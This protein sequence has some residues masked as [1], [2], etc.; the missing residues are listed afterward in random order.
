MSS[1]VYFG[2]N[3]GPGGRISEE[4]RSR[5][6]NF[7]RAVPSAINI[8]GTRTYTHPSYELFL[9]YFPL[10]VRAARL[11]EQVPFGTKKPFYNFNGK[12]VAPFCQIPKIVWS[13]GERKPQEFLDQQKAR[14][15][16]IETTASGKPALT[17]RLS[18]VQV[19][20]LIKDTNPLETTD[21]SV[22]TM[23]IF[24]YKTYRRLH[25]LAHTIIR[26]FQY[27]LTDESTMLTNT[28]ASSMVA[29]PT[30]DAS[31]ETPSGWSKLRNSKRPILRV[32][33]IHLVETHQAFKKNPG[34]T[35][36]FMNLPRAYSSYD[37]CCHTAGDIPSSPG[38]IFPYVHTLARNDPA[39]I[40]A[41]LNNV[42]NGLHGD[43]EKANADMLAT[44][45]KGWSGIHITPWGDELTHIYVGINL[46]M[47]TGAQLRTFTT[48][49]NAYAGFILLGAHFTVYVD[50][51]TYVPQTHVQLQSDFQK[52]SPHS[53]S[54]ER[55][56]EMITYDDDLT[57]VGARTRC[58]SLYDVS[59]AL[60]SN[61]YNSNNRESIAKEARNLC[62][63]KDVYLPLNP[64]TISRVLV[65]MATGIGESEIPLH[66][67]AIFDNDKNHRLLSAFGASCPSFLIDGGRSIPLS[68]NFGY[69]KKIK[70]S[71]KQVEVDVHTM[72][73]A[74]KPFDQAVKD[75]DAV[76]SEKLVKTPAG[77]A[78][79]S[80]VSARAMIREYDGQGG[81]EILAALR[82]AAKVVV[83]DNPSAANMKK[84]RA[85]EESE[86]G[87]SKK[88]KETFDDF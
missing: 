6:V 35:K 7:C 74:V 22:S 64:G 55:L 61:G 29:I 20:D 62:F 49:Q 30:G 68:G 5:G 28:R 27:S 11:S 60:R 17:A 43:D 82:A 75:L 76:L 87:S 40:P 41:I 59:L 66:H 57:R 16:A 71:G 25:A 26:I 2:T 42:L 77:T 54:L 19:R 9:D 13:Y 32:N 10:A 85:E 23:N 21:I 44:L 14:F 80:R 18:V 46:A 48:S 79:A 15:N 12:N 31:F 78:M 36:F 58:R 53:A 83:S 50:G 72:Y 69:R 24:G 33:R 37:H 51:K 34:D 81:L 39:F 47:Q 67:L 86:A 65:C 4:N 88:A 84:R 73:V 38:L 63:V 1:L 70:V 52:A 3:P 8:V 45:L 56:F